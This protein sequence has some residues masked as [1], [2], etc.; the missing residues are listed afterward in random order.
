MQM[1]V[2]TGPS[3]YRDGS[4]DAEVI[5]HEFTHGVSDRLV[6]GGAGLFNYNRSEWAKDGLTFLQLL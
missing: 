3:P 4:L 6:G 2:F 5:L 1:F